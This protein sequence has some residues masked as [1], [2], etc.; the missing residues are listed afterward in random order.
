MNRRNRPRQPT[1]PIQTTLWLAAIGYLIISD[2][3]RDWHTGPWYMHVAG[4]AIGG[5]VVV[6]AGQLDRRLR[7]R[8]QNRDAGGHA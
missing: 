1:G 6:I 3:I 5:A 2:L 4:F 7:I 8:K